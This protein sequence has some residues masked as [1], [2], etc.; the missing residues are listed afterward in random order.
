MPNSLPGTATLSTTLQ[1]TN[2]VVLHSRESALRYIFNPLIT[3]LLSS[4]GHYQTPYVHVMSM[5]IKGMC[6]PREYYLY[7][8]RILF[9][10]PENTICTPMEYYLY[11]QSI[12]FAHPGNNT[13]ISMHTLGRPCEQSERPGWSGPPEHRHWAAGPLSL[14]LI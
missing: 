4:H 2:A 9:V 7:T 11:T 8:Q 1:C 13:C 6:I 5:H 10:Y 12:L 14:S 3:C